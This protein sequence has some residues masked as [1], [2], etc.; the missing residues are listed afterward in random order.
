LHSD[1]ALF[2]CRSN[3]FRVI[4][5]RP[6]VAGERKRERDRE[7]EERERKERD[8]ETERAREKERRGSTSH[9]VQYMPDDL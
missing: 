7:I 2:I 4:W 9:W 5:T 3:Q 6:R 1:G 8:R